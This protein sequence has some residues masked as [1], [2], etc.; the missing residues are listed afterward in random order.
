MKVLVLG[1]SGLLGST[2]CPLLSL[3]GYEV[4]KHGRSKEVEFSADISDSLMTM[5]LLREI[6]PEIIINL[7]SLTDVDYCESQP[8]KAYL[9]NVRT[10]ENVVNWINQESDSC[11]MVHISTDHLYDGS[12]LHSEESIM[13]TNYYAF[14]KYAGE[15][16]ALLASSTILRTNFFGLSNKASR[17][18]ITDWLFQ[19]L[20][21]NEPIQ[22]FED[23][24]FSPLAMTTLSEMIELSIRKKPV[25]IF[26]LG[27]HN[28]MSKADFAFTFA[29]ELGLQS[30]LMKRTTTDRVAFLKTYRPKDMRMDCSKFEFTMGITLPQLKAEIKKAAKEY[31]EIT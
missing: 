21:N 17:A 15:R 8:N 7:V 27:S 3:C 19:S 9:Q 25:G 14:S 6:K 30:E 2:L 13:L 11:H 31:R 23:V 10:V 5:L 12:Y 4:K 16:A 22:V 28:G 29:E 20:S 24:L 1:S 26:N 18:S